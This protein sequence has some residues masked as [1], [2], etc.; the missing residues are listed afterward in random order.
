LEQ[1]LD[2][3]KD[4]KPLHTWPGHENRLRE[5]IAS[6]RIFNASG[7]QTGGHDYQACHSLL[8]QGVAA[9]FDGVI[10]TLTC[11]GRSNFNR[12]AALAFY[13]WAYGP[14]GPYR[15]IFID[16]EFD[17]EFAVDYGLLFKNIRTHPENFIY[18]AVIASRF[19]TEHRAHCAD[20]YERVTKHGI[21]PGLAWWVSYMVRPNPNPNHQAFDWSRVSERYVLNICNGIPAN[22]GPRRPCNVVWGDVDTGGMSGN[23]VSS[24][25]PLIKKWP[26]LYPG[27]NRS[28]PDDL[29]QILLKEQERLELR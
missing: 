9:N 23:S 15:L 12:E 7:V 14:D 26:K 25:D 11:H 21:H 16:D 3:L 20:W 13:K 18:N 1:A 10:A 28:K 8:L 27:L 19:P 17:A 4:P 6:W 5:S 2:W 29:V 24:P 22:P